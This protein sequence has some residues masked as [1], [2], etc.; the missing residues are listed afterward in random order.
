MFEENIKEHLEDVKDGFEKYVD[1]RIDLTKLHLV[2]QLSR[3]TSRFILKS[4]ILYL[5]FFGLLF[6]SLAF[7]LYIGKMV[8]CYVTGFAVTGLFYILLSLIF[9]A[10]R[11]QLI[12]KP[13]IKS[14]IKLF[15]TDFD[16]TE[17]N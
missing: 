5:L 16:E 9:F 2:E 8:N 6:L 14:F 10:C 12:E 4:G 3:L 17:H 13:V 1:K 11:K 7:A 15:F